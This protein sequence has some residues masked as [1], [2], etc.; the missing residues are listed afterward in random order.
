[1]PGDGI[2]RHRP[3]TQYDIDETGGEPRLDRQ[4]CHKNA[5]EG[6]HFR[7]FQH[8][9][10]AGGKRRA[11]LPAGHGHGK[12]P[13]RDGADDTIGLCH[14][15]AEARIVGR[16]QIAAFFVGE[17]G[18]ETDLLGGDG[19]IAGDQL[20][21]GP[22]RGERFDFRQRLGF[23]FDQVGPA[24]QDLCT[25]TR[26]HA[27][28]VAALQ[29]SLGSLHRFIDQRCIRLGT[30]GISNAIGWAVHVDAVCR[31]NQ[32]VADKMADRQGQA[33]WIEAERHVES[34]LD[35]PQR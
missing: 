2:A 18:K 25:L 22:R 3:V 19:D 30:T 4:L 13:R 15:H 6:R 23:L 20:A 24:L 17:F 27:A 33:V 7:G 1:M 8:H 10:I 35:M 11:E 32:P 14:D 21:H 29:R 12:V 26:A 16:H 28:P 31:R 5:G 34:S 9:G